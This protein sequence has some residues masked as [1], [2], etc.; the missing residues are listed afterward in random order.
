MR[1]IVITVQRY[2]KLRSWGAGVWVGAQV[3]ALK[4]VAGDE[5][6]LAIRN[7]LIYCLAYQNAIDVATANQ[8]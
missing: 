4:E 2:D 6:G 3:D 1:F 8:I 7:L 5:I